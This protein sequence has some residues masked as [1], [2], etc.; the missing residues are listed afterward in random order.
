MEERGNYYIGFRPRHYDNSF[1][2]S[3]SLIAQTVNNSDAPAEEFEEEDIWA[4]DSKGHRFKSHDTT[5]N[6]NSR[7]I[8]RKLIENGAVNT[9]RRLPTASRMIPRS[10][11]HDEAFNIMPLRPQS[12]PIN[13]PDWSQI[14]SRKG[15]RTEPL[16]EEDDDDDD[17]KH[18]EKGEDEGI[19]PPHEVV[20]R[21]LATSQMTPFSMC[22]GFGRTLKG[23]DLSR[24]RNAV[25]TR[26]GFL[27]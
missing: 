20:A 9:P 2:L 18:E 14:Y 4:L 10:A 26:T 16:I 6:N 5:G 25:L 11:L 1:R 15:G 13:I 21:Q 7:L 22:E 12:A 17:D 8:N 23:R 27:E 19:V 3:S 24:V